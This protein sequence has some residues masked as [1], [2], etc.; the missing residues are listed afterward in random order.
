TLVKEIIEARGIT[1]TI[2]IPEYFR[3]AVK[4]VQ[5]ADLT[6]YDAVV[7]AGGDGTI[8]ETLNGYMQNNSSRKPPF[9]FIPLGTGNAFSRDFYHTKTPWLEAVD[10]IS[11]QKTKWIDTAFVEAK[12]ES[13]YFVGVTGFGLLTDATIKGLPLKKYGKIAYILAALQC[14]ATLK[15]V[16]ITLTL[17]GKTH[18]TDSFVLSISNTRYIS[19]LLIAPKAIHDDGILDIINVKKMPRFKLLGLIP[20]VYSGKHIKYKEVE[21]LTAKELIIETDRPWIPSPDGELL[22]PTPLKIK[23]IPKSLEIL[24]HD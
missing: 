12:E 10:H 8:Y 7:A 22:A 3:H 23:C 19:D 5:E 13:Y 14:L 2:L 4:M 20:T 15:E 11:R 24:Y 16:Q 1:Y 17:D 18:E 21:Y 6:F 9:G